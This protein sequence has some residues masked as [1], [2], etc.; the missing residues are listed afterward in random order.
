MKNNVAVMMVGLLC[1]AP[2][3]ALAGDT[4]DGIALDDPIKD[5]LEEDKNFA[6][7]IVKAKGKA[8]KGGKGVIT[9]TDGVGNINIGSNANLKGATIVNLSKNKD[10]ETV[11]GKE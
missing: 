9:S 1:L 11:G 4:D 3:F 2:V 8:K 6:Y 5:D 10:N 7:I